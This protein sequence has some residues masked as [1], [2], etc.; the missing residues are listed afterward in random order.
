MTA[1]KAGHYNISCIAAGH[2]IGIT[3]HEYPD[4]V[5]FNPRSIQDNEVFSH[6]PRTLRERHW[7][8][9]HRRYRGRARQAED[10]HV[11]AED[12]GGLHTGL[13]RAR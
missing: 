8:L 4:D 3:T 10:S 2:G 1:F 13:G 12:A 6:E 11:H 7:W 5:P 9:P